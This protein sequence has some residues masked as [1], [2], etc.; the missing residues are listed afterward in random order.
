[1]EETI[2]NEENLKELNLK[3]LATLSA[4]LKDMDMQ[5]DNMISEI[6]EEEDV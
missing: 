6:N 3:E 4:Q 1:M 2:L 5:I